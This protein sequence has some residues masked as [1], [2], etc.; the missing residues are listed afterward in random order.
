MDFSALMEIPPKWRDSQAGLNFVR[1][2]GVESKTLTVIGPGTAAD[3]DLDVIQS[4]AQAGREMYIYREARRT[5]QAASLN[6]SFD[7]RSISKKPGGG[8][9]RHGGCKVKWS[10]IGQQID[11]C[12]SHDNRGIFWRSSAPLEKC[13]RGIKCMVTK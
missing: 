3:I 2:E 13:M 6:P 10:G 11:E 5:N 12:S 1:V 8:K 9:V 7:D 4:Y